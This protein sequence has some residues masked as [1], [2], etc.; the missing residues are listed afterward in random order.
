L[1]CSNKTNPMNWGGGGAPS[2]GVSIRSLRG[3]QGGSS[4]KRRPK[5]S[6]QD[7]CP[8]RLQ[9][10]PKRGALVTPGKGGI[11]F[12]HS[13][14]WSSEGSPTPNGKPAHLGNCLGR[15][16]CGVSGHMG[17]QEDKKKDYKRPCHLKGE[18][19]Q[20]GWDPLLGGRGSL[21]RL[22]ILARQGGGGVLH[23]LR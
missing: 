10:K 16:R 4:P 17:F 18:S 19:T 23:S 20:K 7:Y 3:Q 6:L 5:N 11:S 1:T 2:T 12:F 14:G 15:R 22:F 13:R 8:W 9:V 21:E